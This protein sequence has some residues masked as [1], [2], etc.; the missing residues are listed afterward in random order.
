[1]TSS[2]QFGGK[3]EILQ[4]LYHRLKKFNE[5]CFLVAYE[6]LV[7]AVVPFPNSAT[8]ITIC[9]LL[10][11]S[12]VSCKIWLQQVAAMVSDGNQ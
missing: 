8:Q 10:T 6:D 7:G 9:Q 2:R 12:A 4:H 5:V 3:V 11:S 1:M